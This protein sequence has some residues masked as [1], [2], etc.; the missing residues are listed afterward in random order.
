MGRLNCNRALSILVLACL[1]SARASSDDDETKKGV[2]K[3]PGP[4]NLAQV[5]PL[6]APMPPSV[7][8]AESLM[9]LQRAVSNWN[10]T[11]AVLPGYRGWDTT[12]G[13]P[14]GGGE[15]WTGVTCSNGQLE[16]M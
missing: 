9:R 6:L 4:A 11:V 5:S 13:S 16:A 10:T 15:P 3:D 8:D 1:A 7:G 14:C 12:V 2:V